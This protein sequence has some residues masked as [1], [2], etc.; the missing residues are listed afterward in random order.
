V[1][2][3]VLPEQ[4]AQGALD[5]MFLASENDQNRALQEAVCRL[6]GTIAG[7]AS[8]DVFEGFV[9]LLEKLVAYVRVLPFTD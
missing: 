2:I 7:R 5:D 8:T 9:P 3:D 6:N 1:I 4:C